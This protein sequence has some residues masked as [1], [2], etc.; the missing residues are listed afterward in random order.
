MRPCPGWQRSLNAAGGVSMIRTSR[1]L[2]VPA[3]SLEA[4]VGS[5]SCRESLPAEETRTWLHHAGDAPA[6]L[7]TRDR[8][9]RARTT[10]SKPSPLKCASSKWSPISTGTLRMPGFRL[11]NLW[12]PS[13]YTGSPWISRWIQELCAPSWGKGFSCN[14]A[15]TAS[16]P[17]Q[18][19]HP[20]SRLIWKGPQC[21]GV[22]HGYSSPQV[23]TLRPSPVDCTRGR[24]QPTG[25]KLV[26]FARHCCAQH[27]PDVDWS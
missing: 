3:P 2:A 8:G 25:K 23:H 11:P 14:M 6:I 10:A 15:E 19:E 20:P 9:V 5:G 18:S 4:Y 26:R 16:R 12:A 21:V 24:S 7:P 17:A 13:P 22:G 1:R 27:T